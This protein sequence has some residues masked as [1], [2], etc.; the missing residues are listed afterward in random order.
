M[1]TIKE[2]HVARCKANGLRFVTYR[3]PDCKAMIKAF[4]RHLLG[5]PTAE[6]LAAMSEADLLKRVRL[7][8]YNGR[9]VTPYAMEY[10]RRT[11]G[12][13]A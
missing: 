9:F 10:D 5:I 6:Q 4:I 12:A 7:D 8:I 1:T 13:K 11:M 2:Q 3:C